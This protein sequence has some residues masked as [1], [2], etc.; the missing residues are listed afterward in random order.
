MD[1]KRTASCP[2]KKNIY[3]LTISEFSGCPWFSVQLENICSNNPK[4]SEKLCLQWND[5]KDNII[6]SFGNLRQ[7]N[8]F[9]DVTLVSEDGQQMESHKFVLSS[10]S[11]VFQNLLKG[12]K[13]NHPMIY[14]RGLKSDNLLAILDFLYFF[15]N[16]VFHYWRSETPPSGAEPPWVGLRPSGPRK[17]NNNLANMKY[18]IGCW[19]MCLH[20]NTLQL[21]LSADF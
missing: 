15:C 8:D 17:R 7:E 11:P 16:S 10:S 3:L 9:A 19:V 18:P 6:S 12:N 5:F 4:M 21:T 2:R 13:H 14:M 1:G 20:M